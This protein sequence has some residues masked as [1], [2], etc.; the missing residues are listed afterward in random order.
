MECSHNIFPVYHACE[1]ADW[2]TD[3]T[4]NVIVLTSADS[5]QVPED[6]R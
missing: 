2:P 3:G 6:W 5:E 4:L 1:A